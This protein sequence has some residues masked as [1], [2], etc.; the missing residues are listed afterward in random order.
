MAVMGI[1][2]GVPG[3]T[4]LVTGFVFAMMLQVEYLDVTTAGMASRWL[5]RGGFWG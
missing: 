4:I 5:R 3:D 1:L 2:K